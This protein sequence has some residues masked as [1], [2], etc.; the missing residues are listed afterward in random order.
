[1]LTIVRKSGQVRAATTVSAAIRMATMT[2][3]HGLELAGAAGVA[4]T[5]IAVGVPQR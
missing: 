3:S 1:M 5:E 4:G 2:S